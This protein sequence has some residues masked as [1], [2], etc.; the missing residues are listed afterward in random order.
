MDLRETCQDDPETI[1]AILKTKSGSAAEQAQLSDADVQALLAFLEAL[2]APSALDL[3][4]T[5]P[6]SVPSGLPVGGN[7][8]DPGAAQAAG[9]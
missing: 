8:Q 7:I 2:T 3:S 6:A 4:H 9:R 5:I 1:A